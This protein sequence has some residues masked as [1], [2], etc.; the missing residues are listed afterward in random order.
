[1]K[2]GLFGGA[3]ASSGSS[4]DSQ[5]YKKFIDYVCKAD[6]LGFHSNFV[7]EHHFTG[8][9]QVSATVNLLTFLAARTERIR[10]GTGVVVLPW[11]NPVTMAEQ[12]ATLDLL[13]DGRAE[14]G[15][16]KG[17]RPYEF[18]GFNIPQAEAAERYEEGLAV[19]LQSW[20]ATERFSHEGKFWKF[21]DIIVEPRPI[22][23][24]HPPIWIGA[25]SQSSIEKAAANG[26]NLLLDQWAPPAILK[27]RLETFR[28]GR[29]SSGL[30]YS[31]DQVGV[32]RAVHITHDAAERHA[33]IE[34]RAKFVVDSGALK[35][36]GAAQLFGLGPQVAVDSYE[37]AWMLA[38]DSSVVGTPDEVIAKLRELQEAGVEYVLLSD[39][40][41]TIAALAEFADQIMQEFKSDNVPAMA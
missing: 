3:V 6:E 27:G 20:T 34:S 8:L 16:G 24:P 9:G 31:P 29:A 38:E 37:A 5:N 15:V 13:S 39:V 32:A 30:D 36:P 21:N 23:R 17:Y 28:Q 18:T 40:T 11:H 26:F 19:M 22:Q 12:I 25:G 1:M 33:F 4:G 10:L 35:A 41:T 2:F 7:V 14:I